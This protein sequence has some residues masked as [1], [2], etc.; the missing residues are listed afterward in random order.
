MADGS[1]EA[2]KRKIGHKCCAAASC[3]NRSDNHPD[4]SF[5][6]FPK[7]DD[8]HKKWEIRMR[9]GDSE[10]KSVSNKFC[11]SSHFLPSDFKKSLT[12]HR[13]E[14]KKGT[15]PSIFQ[16]SPVSTNSRGERVNNRSE[17]IAK[18]KHE[19]YKKNAGNKDSL[20]DRVRLL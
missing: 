2:K 8:L 14:L 19:D 10:F 20:S 1:I 11:C 7:D 16:W 9:R 5:H 15:V 18:F 13:R 17:S 6:K 3:S 4:L 12:G